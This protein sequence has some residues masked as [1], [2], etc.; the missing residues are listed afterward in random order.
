M[1]YTHSPPR[2]HPMLRQVEEADAKA[3]GAN[4]WE[5]FSALA[6]SRRLS[7]GSAGTPNSG[8]APKA[9]GRRGLGHAKSKSV[10]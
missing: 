10:Q 6:T 7:V 9:G 3:G 5:E 1:R 8:E 2:M 4:G